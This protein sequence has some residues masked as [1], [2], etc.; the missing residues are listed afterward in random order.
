MPPSA[1]IKES[2]PT[3]SPDGA[4][5]E[6][7]PIGPD[8]TQSLA[9]IEAIVPPL[10]PLKDYVAVNPFLGLS[11]HKLLTARQMLREVRDCELLLSCDYFHSAA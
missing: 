6:L 9:E 1:L 10:W 8:L 5:S 7:V 11:E 4:T 3:A 2:K